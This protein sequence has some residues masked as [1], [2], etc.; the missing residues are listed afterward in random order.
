MTGRAVERE[1]PGPGR[2]RGPD[3]PREIF[4]VME[5]RDV[6][7][8]AEIEE[9]SF[10]MP[11][12]P[13]TFRS[14]LGRGDTL[15]RVVEVDGEPV[16]YAVLWIVLD[17]GELANI[18]VD[19]ERRGRGV[20]SRL[21]ERILSAAASRGVRR[22]HLEVRESNDVARQMYAR[23]GFREVGVRRAYYRKPR[24]DACVLMKNLTSDRKGREET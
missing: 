10:S 14:L 15:T 12:S 6:A 5:P 2:G 1:A 17:H 4:R 23:R 3:G 7:R 9:A 24:E 11:W 19:P 22:V 18:A 21:L 16:A 8:V 13:G 20:G